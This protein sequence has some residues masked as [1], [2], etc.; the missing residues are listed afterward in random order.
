MMMNAA[1]MLRFR[2]MAAGKLA[3]VFP[4]G[5]VMGGETY[6]G[7][8][9]FGTVLDERPSGERKAVR[10]MVFSVEKEKMPVRPEV[11]SVGVTAGGV[12][13]RLGSVDGDGDAE[14]CWVLRF[15]AEVS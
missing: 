13:W 4:G 3:E 7:A 5:L 15:V 14:P 8:I 9:S 10:T 1:A 6:Q 2:G 12:R 11:K